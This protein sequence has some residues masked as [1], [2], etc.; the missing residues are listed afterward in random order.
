M[1]IKKVTVY[2]TGN[3]G[4]R[5][6]FHIAYN[7]ID[8]T[9]YDRNYGLLEEARTKFREF[10]DFYMQKF[11]APKEK[12]ET[13]LAYIAYSMEIAEAAGNA[14]LIIEALPEDLPV[15]KQFYTEL[16]KTAPKNAIFASTSAGL[17][18]VE[19]SE[20]SGRAERFVK[21]HFLEG[22]GPAG[23]SELIFLPG[24]APEIVDSITNFTENLGMQVVVKKLEQQE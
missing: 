14:D 21:F 18:P 13:A 15:K 7:R 19:L 23:T 4:A 20:A 22:E 3:F 24:I 2:G 6:A 16:Q 12:V 1:E 11:N 9:V 10:A 5:I 8:V 17:D